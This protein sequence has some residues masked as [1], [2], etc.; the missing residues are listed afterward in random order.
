MF[1]ASEARARLLAYFK[2]ACRVPAALT[3]GDLDL[4]SCTAV[5]DTNEADATDESR[6]AFLSSTPPFPPTERQ[7]PL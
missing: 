7:L 6:E 3:R 1:Y 5:A 4:M 2:G